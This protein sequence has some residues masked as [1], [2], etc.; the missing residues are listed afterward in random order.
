MN[1]EMVFEGQSIVFRR[2]S[3]PRSSKIVAVVTL[4]M[5]TS[6]FILPF[7]LPTEV[8]AAPPATFVDIDSTPFSRLVTQAEFNVNEEFWFRFITAEEIVLGGSTDHHWQS[9]SLLSQIYQDDGTTLVKSFTADYSSAWWVHLTPGTY[10]IK[11]VMDW[12]GGPATVDIQMDFDVAPVNVTPIPQGSYL[13]PDDDTSN[14]PATVWQP[15]G[16]LV[17]FYPDIP[18]GEIGNALPNG[19]SLFHDRFAKYAA[20][21]VILFDPNL[22]HVSTITPNAPALS[23]FPLIY[24]DG[25]DFYVTNGGGFGALNWGETYKVTSAGVLSGPVAT[26]PFSAGGYATAIAVSRDGGSFYWS[27][28]DSAEIKKYDVATDTTTVLYTVPGLDTALDDIALNFN[29]HPGEIIVLP[30]DSLVTWWYD[31]SAFEDHIIHIASDGTLLNSVDYPYPYRVNHLA[32]SSSTSSNTVAVWFFVNINGFDT[33]ARFAQVDL[34]T[35]ALSPSFDVFMFNE[36]ANMEFGDYTMFGPSSSCPFV[37]LGYEDAAPAA[38]D[39]AVEKEV[40]DA[41]PDEED[42]IVY[43]VTITNNGPDDATGIEVE[44]VLPAEVTYVSDVASQGSYDDATG[45]W[46]VGDLNN[47]EFATLELTV[48]VNDGTAGDT[49]DNTA[50]K[51]TPDDTDPSNDSDTVSVTVNTP[52]P[53]GGGGGGGGGGGAPPPPA[54]PVDE[55]PVDDPPEIPEEPTS[56]EPPSESATTPPAETSEPPLPRTGVALSVFAWTSSIYF[57]YYVIRKSGKGVVKKRVRVKGQVFK[58]VMIN[59]QVVSYCS[60]A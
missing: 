1:K 9:G 37:V 51:T 48:T 4:L 26:I 8:K 59:Y 50:T 19:Y 54:P 23:G 60:V 12:G 7:S 39:L 25:T 27:E 41:T 44:D 28:L 42:T 58:E 36:G 5:I 13:V 30:D 40:D 6:S 21:S 32:H 11:L 46:V 34:T 16:T 17:G 2:K 33:Q 24:N 53:S 18:T 55:P 43:T 14:L 15:D 31:F 35:E 57:V 29:L 47:G 20:N 3:T 10:Y 38:F 52:P 45:V 56:S 49:F 22:S